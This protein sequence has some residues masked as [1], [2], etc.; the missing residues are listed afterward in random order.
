M[1]EPALSLTNGEAVACA[2]DA[3]AGESP[4]PWLRIETYPADDRVLVVVSGDLDIDTEET[5]Q[6]ALRDAVAGSVS[7]IDLDL[8]GV[9]F[10]DCS[11]LN[12]LLR[13]RRR[14][15]A[16]GKTVAIRTAGASVERLLDLTHARPLFA[17]TDEDT[18]CVDADQDLRIE[19][20]QLRQAMQTRPVIDLARGVLM[21]S[22]AL[23]AEDAWKVLVTVSQR[24]NTKLRHV[25]QDLV[26]SVN[27]DPLPEPKQQ[28]LA[29][30]VADHST[31]P[32]PPLDAA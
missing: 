20:L 9:E 15:L 3:S 7:G 14:A 12:V 8:N 31:A 30:A 22:F 6:N 13:M 27:G 17:W 19:L 32:A 10:C 21:A 25:A 26:N 16:D 23:S 29:A 5:L 2:A 1:S 18:Q 28:Q 11:G 24:T 4:H